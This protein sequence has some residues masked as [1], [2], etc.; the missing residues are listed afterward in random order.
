M[1][2][3][4]LIV[5]S[6]A[7]SNIRSNMNQLLEKYND[8]LRLIDCRATYNLVDGTYIEFM[9]KKD[10][11]AHLIGLH[12]LIDLQ[13]IQ[14]WLDRTNYSVK[15]KTILKRIENEKLTDQMVRNSSHF[16]KIE[17]RYNNFSYDNLTT[18]NYTDAIIDFD[19]SRMNSKLQSDY[20]LFE[21]RDE[22]YNYMGIALDQNKGYRYVE[23]FFHNATD[24]YASGQTIVKIDSFQLIDASGHIIVEDRF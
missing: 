24:Q 7:F 1:D 9:Y 3:E 15:L 12:K 10:N 19:S 18:L 13:P 23:S 2:E 11:F 21:S 17:T 16:S 5:I 14:F 22:G 6:E 8:Y 4:P 20:I